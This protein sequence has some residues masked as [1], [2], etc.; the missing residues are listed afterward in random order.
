LT[1][2]HTLKWLDRI[3]G[4][5]IRDTLIFQN[6]GGFDSFL[7]W[8]IE[9]WPDWGT[10]TFTPSFGD[11]VTP[12]SGGALVNVEVILPLGGNQEFTGE[13]HVINQD[14]IEDEAI[15]PV[16]L[17]LMLTPDLE[18]ND[19]IEWTTVQPGDTLTTTISIQNNGTPGSFLNWEIES[20]PDWGQWTFTPRMGSN[21]TVDDGSINI[22]VSV[23]APLEE[24]QNFTG[25]IQIT[26]KE[27]NSDYCLIPVTLS[28]TRS[29]TVNPPTAAFHWIPSLNI[30]TYET[31]QFIDDSA[32]SDGYITVWNWDF[33]DGG[34]AV[35]Q[36]PTHTYNE[37]GIYEI[38]LTVI[39]NN[40]S[41]DSHTHY[42][43]I[44]NSAPHAHAGP[45]QIVNTT[46]VYFNG[47]SSTDQDGTIIQYT[48][49]FGDGTSGVGA[50]VSHNYTHDGWYTVTLAVTDNDGGTHTD[51][52]NITIDTVQPHTQ[53][54]LTGTTG[55]NEW[56]ISPVT[57]TLTATDD[58]SGSNALY[59]SLNHTTWTTYTDP[60]ILSQDNIYTLY[61]Y[62]IDNAGNQENHTLQQIKIDTTRPFLSI[63]KPQKNFLYIFDR[64]LLHI[65][66]GT[67]ILG[68]ITLDAQSSDAVS[69]IDRVE[70]FVDQELRYQDTSEPYTWVYTD[71]AVLFHKHTLQL[72]AYDA[73]GFMNETANIAIWIFHI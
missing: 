49:D 27:N 1:C 44:N 39:D 6:G 46:Q 34:Y 56:Y 33:G 70:F 55:F 59:Y 57:I 68:K 3:P 15:I 8:K 54:T 65:S 37:T 16:Y 4:E 41:R 53:I 31:V 32:D 26:N 28:T 10:W 71:T 20:W 69:G 58:T 64:E 60:F 43:H 47:T 50:M 9:S 35:I 5:T 72:K 30:S 23:V 63:V 66:W 17:T 36:N 51:H 2:N 38:Q 42:L 61:F 7:D 29:S 24:E 48:W 18:G 19:S 22:T 73:A 62:S 11:G 21:L 67:V 12:G 40:G 25:H 45:D 52:C 13:I 14:Y